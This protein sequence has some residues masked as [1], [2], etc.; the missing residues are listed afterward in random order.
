M[1][2]QFQTI[3]TAAGALPEWKIQ[4]YS[5]PKNL[6][7]ILGQTL[8]GL[9]VD[10]YSCRGSRTV[11]A[12]PGSEFAR[13]ESNYSDIAA[14][15]QAELVPINSG[16][17]GA[18]VTALISADN[19][20]LESPLVIAPGDSYMRYG[21][22]NYIEEILA[23]DL[24]AGT[25]T[26]KSTGDRWSYVAL[27]RDGLV[28]QVAE[29]RVI[30]A[31]AT[32]GVFVFRTAETFLHAAEWCLLNKIQTN[33]M[34]YVSSTLNYIISRGGKVGSAETQRELFNYYS[35]QEDFDGQALNGTF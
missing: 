22:Q 6:T 7:P 3:I 18:L 14:E 21:A 12:I 24:D 2:R 16:V 15:R 27:N 4:G 17:K 34:F 13:Y 23:R 31:D 32:T 28:T 10:S 9:A 19:L 33:E 30:G 1:P 26:F 25:V 35:R 8:L 29:K 20:D 5:G 11:I